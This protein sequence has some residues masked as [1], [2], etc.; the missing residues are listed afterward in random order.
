MYYFDYLS[1]NFSLFILASDI[2]GY[3]L[4][5]LKNNNNQSLSILMVPTQHIIYKN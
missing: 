1:E 2:A 3:V 4:C 5:K